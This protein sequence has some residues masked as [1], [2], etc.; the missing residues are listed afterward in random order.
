MPY[1]RRNYRKR[2]YRKKRRTFKRYSRKKRRSTWA[3]PS[4]TRVGLSL[5]DRTFVK[6]RYNVVIID[7]TAA[8]STTWLFRGNDLGDPDMTGT[9]EQPAYYDDYFDIYRN[10]ICHGSKIKVTS[11]GADLYPSQLTVLPINEQERVSFPYGNSISAGMAKY[12]RTKTMTSTSHAGT[13]AIK[14]AMSTKK[15]LGVR[16]LEYKMH[17]QQET[18]VVGGALTDDQAKWYW[19]IGDTTWDG[20]NFT[21]QRVMYVQLTYYCEFYSLWNADY[22]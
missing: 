18:V 17:N 3:N 7:P 20:T 6:L 12:A 19:W 13:K 2:Y 5:K 4:K 16:H 21:N 8:A 11:M 15:A 10:M 9:G 1:R 14:H 22:S